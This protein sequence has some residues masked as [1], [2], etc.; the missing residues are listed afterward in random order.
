MSKTTKIIFALVLAVGIFGANYAFAAGIVPCGQHEDDASSTIDESADCTLC[1][2]FILITMLVNFVLFKLTAPLA[3][4]MLII[5]GAMFMLAAGNPNTITQAR[6]LI[7]SVLIGIVIIYGAYFLIGVFLQSV[8][9]AKW[10][11]DIYRSWWDT[12]S[13]PFT[14][15]CE[16]PETSMA[17]PPTPTPTAFTPPV[18]SSSSW[19]TIQVNTTLNNDGNLFT[20]HTKPIY[21]MA[22]SGNVNIKTPDGYARVILTDESG[23]EHLAYEAAGPFDSGSF[24]FDKWCDE[25]CVLDGIIPKSVDA[26]MSGASIEVSQ[27]FTLEERQNLDQQVKTMGIQSYG[28]A[29]GDS[30]E[31]A[32]IDKINQYI[33]KNDLRWTAG[34]TSVSGYSYEEKKALYGLTASDKTPNAQGFEYYKGG[35]FEM[36][37]E[38]LPDAY[39]VPI[40]ASNLPR[41]FDWRDRHGENW[42][43]PVKDQ[44]QCGSCWAFATVGAVEAMA[45]IYF[46]DKPNW[47]FSEQ[48]LV[49]CATESGCNGYYI[50]RSVAFVE[51]YGLLEERDFPYTENAISCG[52]DILEKK[53]SISQGN[54]Y[55][56]DA[57]RIKKALIE[58]G[59]LVAGIPKMRF[60]WG[61]AMVLVGYREDLANPGA[62]IW[63]LKN[64]WG[65]SL[66]DDGYVELSSRQYDIEIAASIGTPIF[67]ENEP[68]KKIKCVDKDGDDYCYW[69]ISSVMPTT[70]PASCKGSKDCDDADPTV[71]PIRDLYYCDKI[72]LPEDDGKPPNL[73]RLYY[74]SV[75]WIEPSTPSFV[76]YAYDKGV[77][78]GCSLDIVHPTKSELSKYSLVMTVDF[79]SHY[80]G[81]YK[82][83]AEAKYSFVEKGEYDLQVKCWDQNNNTALGEVTRVVVNDPADYP[84]PDEPEPVD[85]SVSKIA[86]TTADLNTTQKYS[87]AVSSQNEIAGCALK[88]N[89]SPADYMTLSE[90]PCKS[91]T[92]SA[93]YKF[94]NRGDYSILARC[95]DDEGN[96]KEGEPIIISIGTDCP[97][98]SDAHTD[99]CE[100]PPLCEEDCGADEECDEKERNA[101]WAERN[102]CHSCGNGCNYSVDNAKPE[103]YKLFHNTCYYNCGTT[104]G[105]NGWSKV[106]IETNC[107]VDDC[108]ETKAFG[109]NCGNT[110]S[111]GTTGCKYLNIDT[112]KE[113][114]SSVCAESGWDNSSC[115]GAEPAEPYEKE[116]Y[117]TE[118]FWNT[119][120]WVEDYLYCGYGDTLVSGECL[121]DDNN[122]IVVF[123]APEGS[124]GW[125]CRFECN[126]WCTADGTI[127]ITC[128]P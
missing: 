125:R 34:K 77:V 62:T 12:S 11:S 83:K 127:K 57:E 60:I 89:G 88:I 102:T 76:V 112:N 113:C 6:K 43:T 31:Q 94:T 45:R 59:P 69:G 53:V 97:D 115:Q 68:N 70:C 22:V 119:K 64:S 8:G 32:K 25:T 14:I 49:S 9:L 75:I 101:G 21:S 7:T 66:G 95:M 96:V 123:N 15:E 44:G 35:I 56:S 84:G 106:Y 23:R 18:P 37:E 51:N 104:C 124:N 114:S 67:L 27:L 116:L 61:H 3:L 52:I 63:S 91:C 117:I 74:A 86:P 5:G 46:N 42:M 108:P 40:T 39:W 93:N 55:S 13:G 120:D 122:D 111:C 98:C 19:T 36:A 82:Y 33:E 118:G 28:D 30:N 73:T 79:E 109:N 85:F 65:E 54:F 24:S 128:Q 80:D 71:G 47:D 16:V 90:S 1:H 92:A 100:D 81:N 103:G 105:S 126:G 17:P 121:P 2:F 41:S 10:T 20:F 26:E 4:L 107:S 78:E 58:E 38:D 72:N 110:R 48:E 99:H 29:M 87:V 50:D